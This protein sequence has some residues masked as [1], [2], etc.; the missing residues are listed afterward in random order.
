MNSTIEHK[1]DCSVEVWTLVKTVN[2]LRLILVSTCM[3][4]IKNQDE[5]DIDCGGKKCPKCNDRMNCNEDCDCINNNCQ[6]KRCHRINISSLWFIFIRSSFILAFQSCDDNIRN[7]DESDIDCGG[8]K[9]SKCDN[10][11]ICQENSDCDSGVCKNQTC[12]RKY[13]QWLNTQ[14]FESWFI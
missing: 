8:I 1:F 5:T 4:R 9:C 13:Y 2:N 7:Q 3:D 10:T 11:R 14:H 6:E 12:V